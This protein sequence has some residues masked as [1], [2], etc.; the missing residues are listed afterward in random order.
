[1]DVLEQTILE[2]AVRGLLVSQDPVDEPASALLKA[3]RIEK[4]RLVAEGKVKQAKAQPPVDLEGAPFELPCEWSWA[5]FPELGDFGRGKA[6]HR[7]RNDPVLFN[8]PLYPVVQTGE[9]ARAKRVIEEY[10]SKYSDEGL[11]QSRLWPAGTL[12]ITI[13]ANIADAAM[14]GFDACFPDSVVGFIPSACIGRAD[15][16]LAFME[17]AKTELIA[18]GPATAQKNINLEI[19]GALLIPLPPLAEMERIVARVEEIRSLCTDLR[20]RLA[21]ARATQAQ[22]AEALVAQPAP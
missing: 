6:K 13:A 18:F 9:V 12:C 11:A 14:L 16:F 2:L 5:R 21:A 20:Q 17:T 10:H 8:P 19:L 4:E 15:Y 1:M 3:I 7:P 22:L